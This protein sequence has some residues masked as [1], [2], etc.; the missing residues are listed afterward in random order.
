MAR[1]KPD[2]LLYGAK[3]YIGQ[4]LIKVLKPFY[5]I[6]IGEARIDNMQEVYED[7]NKGGNYVQVISCTGRTHGLDEK[8]GEPIKTIDYLEQPGKLEENLRD[9]LLG[10]L[11]LAEVCKRMKV[12]YCYIGTGCC[13]TSQYNDLGEPI[14]T[15][16]E[17]DKPNFAGSAYSAVKGVTDLL[18]QQHG[19]ALILRIR[20]PLA[21]VPHP[22]NTVTKLASYKKIHSLQNSVTCFSL[23]DRYLVHMLRYQVKG[24]FN[25][26]NKG[27]I[28]NDEILKLYQEEVDP[29]HTWDVV[30]KLPAKVTAPRSN[31]V[32]KT[33]KLELLFPDLPHAR[34]AVRATLKEYAKRKGGGCE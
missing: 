9:N 26:V 24:A 6:T 23:F 8:T 4:Y 15:Y 22:R 31:V 10:P 13:Y 30:D 34:N 2:L 29:E 5:D 32:L 1:Y 3:G 21:S 25:F 16:D 14:D 19:E 20:L 33:G 7:F 11:V 17:D 28:S 27:S 18:L 12:R